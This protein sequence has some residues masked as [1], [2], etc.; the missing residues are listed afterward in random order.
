MKKSFRA[1]KNRP[2]ITIVLT[3][4]SVCAGDDCDAPHETTITIHSFLDSEALAR[5]ASSGY[6]PSVAG[7]GHS[8]TCLLNDMKVAEIDRNGIKPLV[9]EVDYGENNHIHF[10]YKAAS[11]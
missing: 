5:E 2:E 11:Y 4:D 1:L 8:W 9:R 10:A 7:I 6:L 3:R